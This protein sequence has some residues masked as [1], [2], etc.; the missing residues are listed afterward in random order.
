M[1]EELATEENID[2]K[3]WPRL[4]AIAE[5]FWSAASVTDV[6]SMYRRLAATSQWLETLGLE[7]RGGPRQMLKRL[8]GDSDPAQLEEFASVLE[9]VKGY[10]RHRNHKYS[11]LEPFNRLVA[12]PFAKDGMT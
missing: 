8:A 10:A 9:P 5:R 11:M 3:L 12:Q 7:H 2:A 1:W 6:D 4:A